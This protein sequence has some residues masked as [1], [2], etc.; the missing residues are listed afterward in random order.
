MFVLK[1]CE[2]PADEDSLSPFSIFSAMRTRRKNCSRLC[3]L[4]TVDCGL[5]TVDG[6]INPVDLRPNAVPV[7]TYSSKFK[8]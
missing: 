8:V 7:P 5:W 3:G 4:W 6:R 2:A 1:G